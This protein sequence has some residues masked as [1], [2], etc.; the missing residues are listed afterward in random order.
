[1]ALR[2]DNYLNDIWEMTFTDYHRKG[3]R[4]ALYARGDLNKEAADD[5]GSTQIIRWSGAIYDP[6]M[7]TEIPAF[8]PSTFSMQRS[9]Y[10]SGGDG[11]ISAK[12]LSPV[13]ECLSR[14]E[15]N[16]MTDE[17]GSK[18]ERPLLRVFDDLVREKSAN[19]V[20][21]AYLMQQL[22]AVLR[23]RPYAWG[24]E[25]CASLRNDLSEL[26]RLCNGT[27][28]RSQDWL[29]E[30]KKAQLGPKMIAFFDGLQN[31]NYLTEARLRREV[32]R[33]VFKA[34]LQFG[35]FID[36]AGQSHLLG[37]ARS[38]KS[39]WSLSADGQKLS[40]HFPTEEAARTAKQQIAG[41]SPVFFVPLD[42]DT[43][44]AEASSRMSNPPGA[45]MKLPGVPW[46]E[47]P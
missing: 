27:V 26:D 1:V 2:D 21:K 11:E 25:Y 20:F 33:G 7:K 17:D 8:V 38:S 40:R 28:L 24:L 9:T 18:F 31:R 12:H 4:R 35:G 13:S 37:E 47:N 41:F 22:G 45:Q 15:L 10:G 29:L 44:L 14:L 46:L 42:R 34:G 23:V 3:E 39:L 36:S 32:L 43:V 19:A 16:R 6:A 5:G 30:R